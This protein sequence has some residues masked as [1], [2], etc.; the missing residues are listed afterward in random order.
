MA[1]K[2]NIKTKVI[3][4]G[5]IR[6]QNAKSKPMCGPPDKLLKEILGLTNIS[7]IDH[8]NAQCCSLDPLPQVLIT[9]FFFIHCFKV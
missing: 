1:H 7:N 2:I 8:P 5:K 4:I 9:K 6:L 3:Q